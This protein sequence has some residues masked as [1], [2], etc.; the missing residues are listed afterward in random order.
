MAAGNATWRSLLDR[1]ATCT[2]EFA[3]AVACLGHH[4]EISEDTLELWEK[5]K[6]L[7]TGCRPVADEIERHI[8]GRLR[9]Q[10]S[11]ATVMRLDPQGSTKPTQ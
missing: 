10:Q 2:R 5:I 7:Y 4:P 11:D 3:E 8:N 1:Y 9:P 6:R